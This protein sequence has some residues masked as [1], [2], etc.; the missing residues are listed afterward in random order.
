MEEVRVVH[1]TEEEAMVQFLAAMKG[2]R[3]GR[4]EESD[5]WMAAFWYIKDGVILL[6]RTTW[7]FPGGSLFE[8]MDVLSKDIEK[9]KYPPRPSILRPA[10][11]AELSDKV[12]ERKE[13]LKRAS[14]V[15]MPPL[16]YP[17]ESLNEEKNKPCGE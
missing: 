4:Q 11:L 6:S 16:H 2:R 1:E 12:E 8:A 9:T 14:Q 17:P 15:D 3:E 13:F 7:R 5:C 10:D